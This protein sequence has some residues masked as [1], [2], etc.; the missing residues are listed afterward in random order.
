MER[1][2]NISGN[3]KKEFINRIV[4]KKAWEAI[5][6]AE[7][8]KQELVGHQC[9]SV[10]LFWRLLLVMTLFLL[11]VNFFPVQWFSL[12]AAHSNHLGSFKEIL[13][14]GSHPR[15]SHLEFLGVG[16]RAFFQR[17]PR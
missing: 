14:P 12:L 4:R 3:L 16:A 5:Q 17:F 2:W 13:T 8:L 15:S 7:Y 1:H 6:P 10:C 11:T 9:V